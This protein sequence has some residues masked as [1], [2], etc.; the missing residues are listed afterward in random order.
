MRHVSAQHDCPATMEAWC[1]DPSS[2]R[3]AWEAAREIV[4]EPWWFSMIDGE[5]LDVKLATTV[6][7]H[8]KRHFDA[9]KEGARR[10]AMRRFGEAAGLVDEPVAE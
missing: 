8:D 5:K 1:T 4:A 10:E 3:A 2:K 9:A 6:C 7:R